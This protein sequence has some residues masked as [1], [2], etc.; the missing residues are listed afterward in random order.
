MDKDPQK[1]KAMANDHK[2]H[3]ENLEKPPSITKVPQS[4]RK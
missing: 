4:D 2:D 3:K 1:D